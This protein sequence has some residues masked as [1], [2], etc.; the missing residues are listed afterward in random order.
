[1]PS[2]LHILHDE[3][4]K[5]A[6]AGKKHRGREGL[7]GKVNARQNRYQTFLLNLHGKITWKTG[8]F[9]SLTSPP[10]ATLGC[11]TTKGDVCARCR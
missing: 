7:S 8:S 3:L 6:N 4:G 9:I 1:M 5:R 11:R 2:G 10:P